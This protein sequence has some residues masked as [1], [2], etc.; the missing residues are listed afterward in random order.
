MRFGAFIESL[1]PVTFSALPLDQLKWTPIWRLLH[2][3]S[4]R[5]Q[6][7]HNA[8]PCLIRQVGELYNSFKRVSL[9][10]LSFSIIF[11]LVE[12]GED[13]CGQGWRSSRSFPTSL[14]QQSE[15]DCDSGVEYVNDDGYPVVPVVHIFFPS[16]SPAARGA[17]LRRST[18]TGTLQPS[19]QA[20]ACKIP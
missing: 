20:C 14:Q 12:D 8:S 1:R 11:Q 10:M 16:S 13:E 2:L 17:R 5:C 6:P 9:A 15:L 7:W 3:T 4:L 19:H 18:L